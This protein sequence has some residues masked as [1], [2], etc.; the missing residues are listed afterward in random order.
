MGGSSLQPDASSIQ[1]NTNRPTTAGQRP[2]RSGY[3]ALRDGSRRP[4]ARHG[5]KALKRS[6]NRIDAN[7]RPTQK[8][9][10]TN[11][12]AQLSSAVPDPR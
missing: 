7:T 6:P 10:I 8:M 4:S 9:I 5:L 12:G 2:S 11:V 1:T 3:A